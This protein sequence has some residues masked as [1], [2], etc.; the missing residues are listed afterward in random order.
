[1]SYAIKVENLT[2]KYKIYDSYAKKTAMLI[3]PFSKAQAKE[4]I[5][6]NN[7]NFEVRKGE[8]IGIV[9]NNGA[10]KSTLLKILSGVAFQNE[11]TVDIKGRISSLIELGAGFNPELTGIENI[12]FN[13]SLLGL[14]KEDV[15]KVKDSILEFADIGEFVNHPVKNYSSGMYA[16]LAFAV[17]INIDPDILIVDEIL[18]VGDVGFQEKCMRKFEEFKAAGKTIIYVSHGLQTVQAYCERAIWLEKGTLKEIGPAFDVVENYYKSMMEKGEKVEGEEKNFVKLKDIKI[19]GGKKEFEYGDSI[20]FDLEYDVAAT[21]INNAGIT[22]ELRQA[23]K[24]PGE[25]KNADQFICAIN[26]NVDDFK[27]PWKAGI[28]KTSVT[29]DNLRVAEGTY[30]LDIVFSES[31]NLVALETVEVAIDF[32]VNNK[33]ASQGFVFL[34]E[35]WME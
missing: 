12:Y 5:A 22:V 24:E 21:E 11:G 13:G 29:F 33:R 35:N 18:S 2:K 31:Q 6:L 25:F 14:E 27:I 1:M 16:R 26:S 8:I 9:G 10:G 23:Y 4:F 28:N 20:T 7:L 15:D 3:N 19:R 17:A 34:K 30:Y 32:K